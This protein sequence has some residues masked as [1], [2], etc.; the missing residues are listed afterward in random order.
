[1]NDRN[2][3]KVV[4]LTGNEFRHKFFCNELRKLLHV[5]GV[6]SE[7]EPSESITSQL[8]NCVDEDILKHFKQRDEAEKCYF[9]D[10]ASFDLL[11]SHVLEIGSNRVNSDDVFGWIQERK[12]EVLVLYGCGIIKEGIL[13]AYAERIAN[14][15][16]G[17]SPYY[18]GSGTNFW[19]LVHEEPECVGGTILQPTSIID[20]G[21]ILYQFRPKIMLGDRN[22]DLGCKTI[23]AGV[24]AIS[25]V[26]NRIIRGKVKKRKQTDSGKYYQF[27]D[28]DADAVRKIWH[29]IDAGMIDQYIKNKEIRDKSFPLFEG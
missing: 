4:V 24:P 16:L 27:N 15:H 18:R 2:K 6:V 7:A 23:I 13:N 28:F 3:P 17:L 29:L 22:H 20:G 5:N 9:G 1:M 14:L 12:P 19:A 26:V 25:D 11:S 21:P 10:H 8:D